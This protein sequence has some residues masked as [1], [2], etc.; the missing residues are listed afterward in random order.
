M[1]NRVKK[2]VKSEVMRKMPGDYS[3]GTS[4]QKSK[5]YWAF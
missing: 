2:G 3:A 1:F 5:K 4:D